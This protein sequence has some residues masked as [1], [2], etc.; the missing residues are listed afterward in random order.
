M[1]TEKELEKIKEVI[2][3]ILEQEKVE[4]VD[5]EYVRS[6]GTWILR[7]YIDKPTGVTIGDCERV[8]ERIG[9]EL[10]ILDIIQVPYILE[11][12][13]PGLERELKTE[14]DFVRSLGKLVQ[15][16]TSEAINGKHVFQG[17]LRGFDHGCIFIKDKGTDKIIEIPREKVTS[18][19]LAVDWA[20]EFKRLK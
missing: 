1:L 18:A 14:N 9:M 15:I 12:S 3:P 17:I 8:S 20:E 5:M 2:M 6:G 11:V 7:F 13:S 19:R 10:D 4:L 16:T